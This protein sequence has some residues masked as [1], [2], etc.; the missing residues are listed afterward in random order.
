M[1]HD[2]TKHN[3]SYNNILAKEAWRGYELRKD[4]RYKLLQA[5][6]LF[7]EYL[8]IPNF[9]LIDIVL[10]G[11]MA[12]FNYTKYSDFDVHVV[13]RYRDLE[14]DDLAEAFYRAK[15]TIWNDQHDVIIR[16]HEVELYVEDIDQPPVSSGI[17]SLLD[18]KWTKMPEYDPPNIAD[19][20][21]N[22]KVEDLIHQIVKVIHKADDANDIQ[23]IIDKLRRM[24]RSGLDK[25]GEFSVENLSYKILRNLGYL[26]RLSRALQDQQDSNLSL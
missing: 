26:D 16:G 23:R 8:E 11:S 10:T 18:N 20:A 25:G 15:K 2:F 3:I 13:T 14:C 4:V 9:K 5:A 19:Q 21:V 7:I 22:I 17:F 12:N 1:P 6:K 24:R